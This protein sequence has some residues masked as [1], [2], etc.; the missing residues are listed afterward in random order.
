MLPNIR[1]EKMGYKV[2]TIVYDYF[3]LNNV[4]EDDGNNANGIR[5]PILIGE[6]NPII[7]FGGSFAFGHYLKQKQTFAYK[8][9]EKLNRNVYNRGIVGCGINN[10]LYQ[11][12][13]SKFYETVPPSNLVFYLMINDHYRRLILKSFHPI[14]YAEYAHYVYNRKKDEMEMTNFIPVIEQIEK[15]YL[16]KLLK[17]FYASH[18]TKSQK[19]TEKANEKI[20]ISFLKAREKLEK[21][22]NKKIDFVV[23]LYDNVSFPELLKEKLEQNGFYVIITNELTDVDLKS[24]TYLQQDNDHPTEEAWNLLTPLIIKN[25]KEKG[26]NL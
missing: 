22:W 18:Y 25:L 12:N 13:S 9:A 1:V 5:K 11:I 8:L 4:V 2:P 23:I 19:C 26:L 16:V 6:N 7:I 24:A 10:M 14:E 3:Y 21:K 15:S 20:L 17:N